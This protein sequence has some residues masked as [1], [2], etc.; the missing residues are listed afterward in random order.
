MAVSDVIEKKI[1]Q[2]L[3]FDTVAE[4]Y[5]LTTTQ[6]VKERILWDNLKAIIINLYGDDPQNRKILDRYQSEWK[7]CEKEEKRINN[8]FY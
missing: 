5:G 1:I 4:K 3:S 7:A 6:Q 2:P 8:K